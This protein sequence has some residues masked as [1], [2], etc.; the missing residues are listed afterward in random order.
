M[1]DTLGESNPLTYRGYVYDHETGLYYVSSRYYDPEIGRWINADSVIAGVGGEILGYNMF[2][3]CMNNTVNRS[4]PSGNW[5]KWLINAVNCVADALEITTSIGSVATTGSSATA[6]GPT[7]SRNTSLGVVSSKA[8]GSLGYATGSFRGQTT[9]SDSSSTKSMIGGFGKASV[10]NFDLQNRI[11]SQNVGI[12]KKEVLDVGTITSQAGIQYKKGLGVSFGV[13][14]SVVA[15]RGTYC[16]DVFGWKVEVGMSAQFLSYG[17]EF[18][19]GAL[20]EGG[21]GVKNGASTGLFGY[22]YLIRITP[23]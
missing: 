7:I 18:A 3:Y 2:A 9:Q 11:G 1:A 13:K 23:S 21:W 10:L 14:V 15:A 20:P 5:P 19:Y 17:Y 6:K 22:S 16:V 8:S 4:D 12:S